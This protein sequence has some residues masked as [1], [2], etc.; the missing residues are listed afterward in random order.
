MNFGFDKK[1]LLAFFGVLIFQ[2]VVI[3]TGLLKKDSQRSLSQAEIQSIAVVV[4]DFVSSANYQGEVTSEHSELKILNDN[5]GITPELLRRVVAQELKNQPFA[6]CEAGGGRHDISGVYQGASSDSS[7]QQPL[8]TE[9]IELQRAAFDTS[10]YIV[11]QAISSGVWNQ[12]NSLELA[13]HFTKL[14]EP[15]RDRIRAQLYGAINRQEV[16][17]EAVPL[18]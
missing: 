5:T 17:L 6:K 4:A 3:Y 2:C 12:K 9:D 18:L 8:T 11:D 14:P 1:L 13:E 15:E 16:E 7:Y 10:S